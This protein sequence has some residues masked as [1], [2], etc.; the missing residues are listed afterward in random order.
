M[1]SSCS[2]RMIARLPL[3]EAFVLGHLAATPIAAEVGAMSRPARA[4]LARAVARQLSA[5]TS[6]DRLAFPEEVNVVTA[7]A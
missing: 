3:P 1:T 5:Y 2:Q 4:A 6:A 7:T